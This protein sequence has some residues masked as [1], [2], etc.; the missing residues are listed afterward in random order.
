MTLLE[1]YSLSICDKVILIG[2]NYLTG[3]KKEPIP[4]AAPPHPVSGPPPIQE[5]IVAPTMVDRAQSKP[6]SAPDVPPAPMTEPCAVISSTPP[7]ATLQIVRGQEEAPRFTMPLRD[8][9]VNDG[10][11]AIFKVMYRGTPKPTI[12]WFFNSQPIQPSTDF[13]IHIDVNRGE[14]ILTIK[15]VFPDDEG[16]YMCRAENPL[17]VAVTHC[18]LFVKCEYCFHN[19]LIPARLRIQFMVL[20]QVDNYQHLQHY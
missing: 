3:E 11:S 15:E 18:H 14:T 7:S 20:D 10:D 12:N 19:H 2:Y 16:E 6:E 13:Q 5:E 17:G 9:S 1:S 4:S 8:L